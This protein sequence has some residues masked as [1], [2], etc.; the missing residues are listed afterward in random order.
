MIE[1]FKFDGKWRIKIVDET[2]QFENLKDFEKEL[3]N[4]IALKEKAEPYKRLTLIDTGKPQ[5]K[6]K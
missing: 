1:I 5:E 2:L 6:R 4:L 3:S